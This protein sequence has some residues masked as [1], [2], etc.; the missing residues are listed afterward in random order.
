MPNPVVHFEVM[1][2]D[3]VEAVRSFYAEAFG[4]TINTDN[5]ANYGLVDTGAGEGIRGGIG[6]PMDGPSYA[7]FYIQVDNL[8]RTLD[9]IAKLGGTKLMPPMDVPGQPI[10]IAMF[11]DPAGNPIGLVQ[12]K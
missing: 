3:N 8:E 1:A 9:R 10:A 12:N 2:R 5:P 4:W 11:K 6:K 7:T